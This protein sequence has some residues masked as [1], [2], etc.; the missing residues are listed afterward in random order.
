MLALRLPVGGGL[1]VAANEGGYA[2]TAARMIGLRPIVMDVDLVTMAPT[3][4]TAEEAMMSFNGEVVAIVVTHLHGDV[5]PLVELERWRKARGLAMVEDCSQAHGAVGVGVHGD[6][7]AYSFY[8][9]KNLGAA[10][11]AGAVTFADSEAAV[12]ARSLREYGWG[13]RSR[14]DV[15]GG[16]NSRLDPMQAAILSARLPFL[17]GRNQRRRAIHDAYRAALLGGSDRLAG[18]TR[19]GVAHH[20]VVMSSNRQAL[21]EFLLGDGIGSQ[22]HYPY[23]VQE[24]PGLSLVGV[25][26]IAAQLREQILS[27]P[28]YPELLDAEVD[29]VANALSE[30]AAIEREHDD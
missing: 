8:P 3:P 26:P 21:S 4:L 9:T 18:E 27:V 20:A 11:D 30:W 14:V 5:V 6:A 13:V 2:A 16:R 17:A 29:R 19:Y 12:R 22:V 1:L 28:C 15:A 24:M 23:L 25:T 10:G 7:A